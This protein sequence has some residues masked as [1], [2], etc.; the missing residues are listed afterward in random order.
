MDLWAQLRRAATEAGLAGLGVTDTAPFP[1]VRATIHERRELGY[2]GRLKFTYRD[3]ETATDIRRTYPWARALIVGSYPYLPEAGSPARGAGRGRIARFAVGDPYR[4]LRAALDSVAGLVRE[5]GHRAE[6]VADDNRLVDR[7]AAVRAGIGWWGKNTMV[8]DPKHGPWLLLGSVVTDAA[9]QPTAPMRRDCGTCSACLPACPTGALVAPGVLDSR[10]C[11]AHWA[12]A[13]GDIPLEFRA[14]MGDRIYG[15]DDCLEACPPG[16]HLL[17]SATRAAGEVDLHELLALPDRALLERFGHMYLPKRDPIY[18]R[19][20][21]LVALGN[22]GTDAD[23]A[24]LAGFLAHPSAM[25]RRHAAW[26]LGRIGTGRATRALAAAPAALL[27]S[28]SVA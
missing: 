16:R 2:A 1:D 26:A 15:C 13:P 17:G 14:A 9:L 28:S 22:T 7:A 12:Q 21:A 25:L 20:N 8:L 10:R 27:G 23:V 24:A 11:L 3:P 4:R 18:L 6:V 19:R 5:T